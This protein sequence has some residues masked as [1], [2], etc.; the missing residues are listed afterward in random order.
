MAISPCWHSVWVG[1]QKVIHIE[2]CDFPLPIIEDQLRRNAV[3]ISEF[4]KDGD[5]GLLAIR[6]PTVA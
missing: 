1:R 4:Q 5:A 3:R 6:F 2:A